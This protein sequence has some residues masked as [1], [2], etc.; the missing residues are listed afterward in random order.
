MM[1]WPSL[2]NGAKYRALSFIRIQLFVKL[3]SNC[4]MYVKKIT[5][6]VVWVFFLSVCLFFPLFLQFDHTIRK[7]TQIYHSFRASI[8][9]KFPLKQN[10]N[11][12]LP[13]SWVIRDAAAVPGDLLINDEIGKTGGN[14]L[15]KKTPSVSCFK[16]PGKCLRG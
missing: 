1:Q 4:L 15:I 2:S 11:A 6:W 5:S 3:I 13:A 10:G 7:D 16:R 8:S 14:Y 12:F 9:V